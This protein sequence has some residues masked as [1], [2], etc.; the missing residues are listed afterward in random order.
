MHPENRTIELV[1]ILDSLAGA[2]A[3]RVMGKGRNPFDAGQKSASR[4][5]VNAFPQARF[6]IVSGFADHPGAIPPAEGAPLTR[7]WPLRKIKD[8]SHAPCDRPNHFALPHC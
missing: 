2:L 1:V 4:R 3:Y 5:S 7:G 6:W 8:H